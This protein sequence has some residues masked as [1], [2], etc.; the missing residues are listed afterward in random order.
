MTTF[1]WSHQTQSIVFLP[2]R[3][4]LAIDVDGAP[5]STHDDDDDLHVTNYSGAPS[6][7]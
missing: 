4:D 5:G 3:F 7:V 1:L 6:V 2:K